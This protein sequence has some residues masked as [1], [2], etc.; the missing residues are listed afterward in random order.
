[1]GVIYTITNM[2]DQN[3]YVGSTC[4]Y[5]RRKW[6]HRDQLKKGI[7]SCTRLQEAWNEYGADNFVFEIVEE[8]SDDKLLQVEDIYLQRHHGSYQCYNVAPTAFSP[9]SGL[10]EVRAKISST[11]KSRYSG[12]P[13]KHPR[14]GKLHTE[15]TRS[16]ISLS[17]KGKASGEK[18]YRFG[19]Q[20]P[21]EVRRKISEK[22]KGIPKLSKLTEEGRKRRRQASIGN[23]NFLG[24]T[25]SEETKIKMGRAIIAVDPTGIETRYDTITKCREATG[26]KAPTINNV[27]IFKKPIQFGR[28]RG[29]FF[30]YAEEDATQ[31]LVLLKSPT[32]EYI[33]RVQAVHG[34]R[35]NYDKTKYT[36]MKDKIVVGCLLHGEFAVSASHHLYRA[37]GCPKC[38]I[39]SSGS[40]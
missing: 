8:V 34:S 25:H 1:M 4:K 10:P 11:L 26:F 37:Q 24:K 38:I 35:Y 5:E 20:V 15:E 33:E 13:T 30:R 23:T 36:R 28:N 22:Q 31:V 2:V 14:F 32:D 9:P 3:F 39:G 18:H 12:D 6:E 16:K 29:W 19:S 27:L 7:H 21:E 40:T 17:R